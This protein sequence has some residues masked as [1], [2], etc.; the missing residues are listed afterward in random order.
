MGDENRAML[1]RSELQI[2]GSFQL[3]SLSVNM[4]LVWFMDREYCN[5]TSIKIRNN[6]SIGT[7]SALISMNVLLESGIIALLVTSDCSIPL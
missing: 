7:T 4:C 6:T 3:L 5:Y 2:T 1:A